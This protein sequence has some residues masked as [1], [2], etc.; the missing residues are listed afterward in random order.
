MEQRHLKASSIIRSD[1]AFKKLQF[2]RSLADKVSSYVPVCLGQ[3]TRAPALVSSLSQAGWMAFFARLCSE[4]SLPKKARDDL[5]SCVFI[6]RAER[7]K[8]SSSHYLSY[9]RDSNPTS[10][11]ILYIHHL[12][13]HLRIQ[14]K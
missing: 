6:Q 14:R 7:C 3:V 10:L 5:C 1:G 9:V 13:V 4:A 8:L 11:F 2:Y 12:G